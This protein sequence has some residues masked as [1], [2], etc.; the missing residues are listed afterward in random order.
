MQR[1]GLSQH[2]TLKKSGL[3]S[4]STHALY[5]K[6]SGRAILAADG[7]MR[8]QDLVQPLVKDESQKKERRKL[9]KF[10]TLNVQQISGTQQQVLLSGSLAHYI[11]QF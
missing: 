8:M 11:P 3:P 5:E 7:V 4:F 10:I 2:H 9:D 1:L 6:Q